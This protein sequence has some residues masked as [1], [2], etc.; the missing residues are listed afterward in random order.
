MYIDSGA[1][2]LPTI[3]YANHPESLY[4]KM[5]LKFVVGSGFRQTALE[6]KKD[7]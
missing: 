1:Q 2:A 3:R 4:L 5:Y 6:R 7:A